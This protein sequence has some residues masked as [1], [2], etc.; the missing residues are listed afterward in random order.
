MTEDFKSNILKYLT[1]KFEI[2]SK[3]VGT[4][5]PFTEAGT[6]DNNLH[7]TLI[8]RFPHGYSLGSSGLDNTIKSNNDINV[9]WGNYFEDNASIVPTKGFILLLSPYGEIIQII[10][11]YD[12]GTKIGFI[13]KLA[14]DEDNNFY[15]IINGNDFTTPYLTLLNNFTVKRPVDT[16][17]VIKRRISYNIDASIFT[18]SNYIDIL[19]K[20]P[21]YSYY[22]IGNPAKLY[23]IKTEVEGTNK[24]AT[25]YIENEH[26]GL[27]TIGNITAD[28]NSATIELK[29]LEN[30]VF[31]I[32]KATYTENSGTNI[33]LTKQTELNIET[34]FQSMPGRGSL[35]QK[36]NNTYVMNFVNR[37]ITS[38]EDYAISIYRIK[39][40]SEVEFLISFH[41]QENTSPNIIWGCLIETDNAIMLAISSPQQTNS[42]YSNSI[43]I[44]NEEDDSFPFVYTQDDISETNTRFSYRLLSFSNDFNLMKATLYTDTQ[45]ITYHTIYNPNNYNGDEYNSDE[46]MVPQYAN[47]YNSNNVV[48]F[49]RNLYNKTINNNTTTSTIEIPN[50]YLNDITLN[51]KDLISKT[52]NVLNENISPLVKNIYESLYINFIN[53]ITIKDTNDPNNEIERTDGEIA[54]NQ[55]ISNKLLATSI[56]NKYKIIY[57]L[58]DDVIRVF[59]DTDI[60]V[61]TN[62]LVM[63]EFNILVDD[64]IQRIEI[65]SN[66]EQITYATIN[67]AS[68]Q[69]GKLY[70]IT[71]YVE[72]N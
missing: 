59:E 12:T 46:T 18:D 15:G 44:I 57:R 13:Y 38:Q 53:T 39:H 42:K 70:K 32:Y 48:I 71:Q 58:K 69:V 27:T 55:E 3:P 52:N 35:A 43:G 25:F 63:Y 20:A 5:I 16:E 4:Q 1:N 50:L 45:A 24:E 64:E 2:K 8:A 49:S 23:M 17:Y 67:G 30:G 34:N 40:N 10:D 31:Y 41:Q 9:M 21:N 26:I 22:L 66:D 28:E 72:I 6:I 47:I 11:E 14:V 33:K 60:K 68:L 37:K 62:D 51:K 56:A 29:K 36:G 19:T 65:I 61:L 54:L 7:E